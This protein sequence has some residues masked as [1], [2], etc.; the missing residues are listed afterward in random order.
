[1]IPVQM[2]DM[3]AGLKQALKAPDRAKII[4]EDAILEYKFQKSQ[5]PPDRTINLTCTIGG[6]QHNVYSLGSREGIVQITTYDMESPEPRPWVKIKCPVEQVFFF[7][8]ISEKKATEIPREI[9][10]HAEMEAAKMM[11]QS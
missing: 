2:P 11:P 4:V 1:M 6:Q 10:F 8:I 3:T 5:L 7:I 9:G